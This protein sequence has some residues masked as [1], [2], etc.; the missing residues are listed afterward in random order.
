[1]AT[2]ETMTIH[3]ALSELKILN[4][5]ISDS[6]HEGV[7]CI[8]NKHSNEKV[9]GVC[10]EDYKKIM[11]GCYDKA[12]DLIK[13]AD[14]IK[15]A[16]VTSNACTKVTIAGT[17]YTVSEA[18]YMKDTGIEYKKMML[19]DMKK[20]YNEAQKTILLNN[21]IELDRRAENYVIG[22]YGGGEKKVASEEMEKVKKAF[23]KANEYDLVDPINILDKIDCLENEINSFI[24]DV[25]GALSTSNAITQITIEY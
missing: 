25:D 4:K 5:R 18:I 7:Y 22:L 9:K 2:T 3:K 8:A 17:E 6:I 11:T 20:Q 1:M 21:G 12:N 10:I 19:A 15:R 16:V 23:I 13:R 14:A 24:A